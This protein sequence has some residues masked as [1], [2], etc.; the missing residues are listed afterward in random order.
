M[1]G[2]PFVSRQC[3]FDAYVDGLSSPDLSADYKLKFGEVLSTHFGQQSQV[4]LKVLNQTEAGIYRIEEPADVKT[5][6]KPQPI[7]NE[8]K[9]PPEETKS[10]E[11]LL[12]EKQME[13]LRK[14]MMSL[15]S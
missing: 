2:I 8:D 1:M 11:V 6:L 3:A 10:P 4:T 15:K 12:L 9:N 7:E 5:L 13:E 14:K